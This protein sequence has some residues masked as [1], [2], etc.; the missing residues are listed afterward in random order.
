M[1]TI[2]LARHGQNED[3]VDGILN[4][5][6]DRPLTDKGLEQAE[7]LAAYIQNSG[8]RFDKIYTSPLLRAYRTAEIIADSLGAEKPEV[9]PLLIERDFGIMTGKPLGQIEELCSPDIIKTDTVTYFLSPKGAETFPE[10]LD[11]GKQILSGIQEEH[12]EGKILLVSHDNIGKMIYCAYYDLGWKDVLT[13]FHFGN[14]D[15]LVLSPS[16][17]ASNAYLYQTEQYN[18]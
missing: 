11:R 13:Q 16:F 17:N 2:Y 10:L 4:G 9:L 5:H 8:V 12:Q 15:V 7:V 18:L 1:L 6:R 14:S 3:N